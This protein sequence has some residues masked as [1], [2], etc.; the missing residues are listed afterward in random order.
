[1]RLGPVFKL[2]EKRQRGHAKRGD[3]VGNGNGAIAHDLSFDQSICLQFPQARRSGADLSR[4][5]TGGILTNTALIHKKR[6][7]RDVCDRRRS[8]ELV[9]EQ[10]A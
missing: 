9:L 5:G 4:H 2:G 1:M 8:F 3:F 10:M 6:D 7:R